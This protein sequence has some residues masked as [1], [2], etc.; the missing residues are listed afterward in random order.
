MKRRRLSENVANLTRPFD[1]SYKQTSR[2]GI[3]QILN[4]VNLNLIGRIKVQS[5]EIYWALLVCLICHNM[6]KVLKEILKQNTKL[7]PEL[8]QEHSNQYAIL[9]KH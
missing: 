1:S 5:L 9:C 6:L 8:T 2:P 4:S 3:C 7:S